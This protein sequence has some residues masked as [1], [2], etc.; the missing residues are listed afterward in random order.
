MI[1]SGGKV[2]VD[3]SAGQTTATASGFGFPG[4]YTVKFN[5]EPGRTYTLAVSPRGESYIPMAAFGFV[6]SAVDAL[7]NENGG[8]FQIQV[9]KS[10]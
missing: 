7:V 4:I 6:G 1:A 9:A 3:I 10:S 2:L 8:A 5:A